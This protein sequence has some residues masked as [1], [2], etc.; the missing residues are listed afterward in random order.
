M[1][2]LEDVPLEALRDEL[3]TLDGRRPVVRLLAA[4]IYKQGPS[5]PTIADW[6]DVRPATVYGWFDRIEAATTLDA[7]IHDDPRPG[8]PAR[9]STD[10]RAELSEVLQGSPRDAGYEAVEWTPVLA[11]AVIE[12]RFGVTYSERHARRLL[13]ELL[14]G[15]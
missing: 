3:E 2:R 12:D 10:E 15:R 5:V 6:L 8:R 9:L 7:A 11:V 1:A 14:G 4:I 13:D